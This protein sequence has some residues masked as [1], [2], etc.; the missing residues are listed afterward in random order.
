MLVRPLDKMAKPPHN[1]ST[2]EG[3]PRA[4]ANPNTKG[5]RESKDGDAPFQSAHDTRSNVP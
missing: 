2:N 3:A 5:E 4:E 1:P